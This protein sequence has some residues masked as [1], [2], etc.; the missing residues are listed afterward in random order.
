RSK[1]QEA[2]AEHFKAK[3]SAYGDSKVGKAHRGCESGDKEYGD[4]TQSQD[5]KDDKPKTSV[6]ET[7]LLHVS[8]LILAPTSQAFAA[9]ERMKDD[10]VN[11]AVQYL[12][13]LAKKSVDEII[14][15]MLS[16]AYNVA[17]EWFFAN[18]DRI[19][20]SVCLF[21]LVFSSYLLLRL[22]GIIVFGP[23]LVYLTVLEKGKP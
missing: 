17:E 23:V 15:M 21:M 3:T 11:Q 6:A 22:F 2:N 4:R 8:Q 18:R 12:M 7:A 10:A 14:K 5:Y 9:V 16:K 20:L 19:A 1:D 13:N